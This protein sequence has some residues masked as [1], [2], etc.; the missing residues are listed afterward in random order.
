MRKPRKVWYRMQRMKQGRREPMG[1]W[2]Y[3]EVDGTDKRMMRPEAKMALRWSHS[4]TPG[5]AWG[6]PFR[7]EETAPPANAFKLGTFDLDVFA[8]GFC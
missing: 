3:V 4:V 2:H 7:F 6:G 1:R 5:H 8:E